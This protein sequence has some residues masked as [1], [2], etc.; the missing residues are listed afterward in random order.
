MSNLM[1]NLQNCIATE[2][3]K[4]EPVL[5]TI[6]FN[7]IKPANPKNKLVSLTNIKINTESE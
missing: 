2:E 5:A 7:N 4:K 6:K 1:I 3:E